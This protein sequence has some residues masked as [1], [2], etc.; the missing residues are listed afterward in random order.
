MDSIWSEAGTTPA[1]IEA[2]LRGLLRETH[3]DGSAHSPARALNFVVCLDHEW[4]G[5]VVNRLERVG[6]YHPSR[7]IVCSVE[8]GRSALDA[9]ASISCER[10]G[11]SPSLA[12][13]R[14]WVE[15]Q[16]GPSHLPHLDSVV[17]PIL[18]AD[19]PC[20][21][22]SPHRHPEAVESLVRV[23]DAVL[24]D[25]RERPSLSAAVAYAA[26]LARDAR[27]VDLAWLRVGPWRERIAAMFDPPE[28]RRAAWQISELTVRHRADSGMVALLLMGWLGGLL[29]WRA[30]PLMSHDGTLYGRLRGRRQHV[31]VRL[32]STG[33]AGPAGLS[34]VL[35]RTASEGSLSLER[36]PAGLTATRRAP[37]GEERSWP[38][39]GAS[40]GEFRI[41]GEGIREALV[42]DPA[43]DSALQMARQVMAADQM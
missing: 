7:T 22:W 3:E 32:E 35:M 23:A 12:P 13:C 2:A 14:E 40:R 15:V 26:E 9:R 6:R 31:E 27:V 17:R 39:L 28:W 1:A 18:V 42:G 10:E 36:S 37:K 20:V 30:R 8:P 33:E 29:D 43:Y 16:V 21:V 24:V 25:T 38:V 34:A 11:P 19:L 4:R 5:E 41:L